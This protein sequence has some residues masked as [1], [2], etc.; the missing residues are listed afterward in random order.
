MRYKNDSD[1]DSVE[2]ISKRQK[3]NKTRR[4]ETNQEKAG[5]CKFE[6]EL[7]TT[8][9]GLLHFNG[10]CWNKMDKKEREFV[11]EY[12]AAVKHGDP[13]ENVTVPRGV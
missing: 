2:H 13:V 11:Q 6:G 12:N 8:D 10:D 4:V 7:D 9:K 3:N 5:N 1:D